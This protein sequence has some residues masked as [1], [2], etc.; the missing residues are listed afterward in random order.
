MFFVVFSI[1]PTMVT[2]VITEDFGPKSERLTKE[3]ATDSNRRGFKMFG[4]IIVQAS[5]IVFCKLVS[6]RVNTN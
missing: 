2:E 3:K 5:Y 4:G 6:I 1:S